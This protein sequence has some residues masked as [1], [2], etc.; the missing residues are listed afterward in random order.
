MVILHTIFFTIGLIDDR[1]ILSATYKS[2]IL[3]TILFL[4]IPISNELIINQINFK[5]LDFSINLH[6]AAIFFTIF[7][8]FALCNAFNFSDGR[9]GIASSLGIFWI[10]FI[11]IKSENYINFYYQSILISL[12]I[13][14]YFNIRKKIFLGN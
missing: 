7:S 5:H 2:L 9:N 13:I 11:L 3:L 4:T 10:L 1:K 12:I 8:I 6:Q 14:L